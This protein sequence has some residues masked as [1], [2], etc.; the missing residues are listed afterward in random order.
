MDSPAPWWPAYQACYQQLAAAWQ[1]QYSTWSWLWWRITLFESCLWI[2]GLPLT[3]L[4]SLDPRRPIKATQTRQSSKRG[5]RLLMRIRHRIMNFLHR[6]KFLWPCECRWTVVVQPICQH[7]SL[8]YS[9]ALLPFAAI[10]RFG[11]KLSKI[12]LMMSPFLFPVASCYT[13]SLWDSP[14]CGVRCVFGQSR[15]KSPIKRPCGTVSWLCSWAGYHGRAGS[16][17]IIRE[18]EQCHPIYPPLGHEAC[19]TRG[20]EGKYRCKSQL[21]SHGHR[22]EQVG[23]RKGVIAGTCFDGHQEAGQASSSYRQ[24]K[25]EDGRVFY[26]RGPHGTCYTCARQAL[27]ASQ[28]VPMCTEVSIGPGRCPILP[29]CQW[30]CSVGPRTHAWLWNHQE[31]LKKRGVYTISARRLQRS[32]RRAINGLTVL[33]STN[34]DIVVFETSQVMTTQPSTINVDQLRVIWGRATDQCIFGPDENMH[35]TAGERW[36]TSLQTDCVNGILMMTHCAP[37]RANIALWI[38]AQ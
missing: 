23:D 11:Y 34:T 21:R 27:S 10:V 22:L 15:W 24:S 20:E 8:S 4:C 17:V 16:H 18:E 12:T 30:P 14:P 28:H 6:K 7:S 32:H 36:S 13:A 33:V 26:E 37:F 2:S 38:V 35:S 25:K 9:V 1:S 19:S 31:P 3:L 5:H 29:H